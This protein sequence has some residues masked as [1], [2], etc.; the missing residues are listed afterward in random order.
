VCA[1]LSVCLS[2]FRSMY[3]RRGRSGASRGAAAWPCRTGGRTRAGRR[4][5]ANGSDARSGTARGSRAKA[6]LCVYA[7]TCAR[8]TGVRG[9]GRV[10]YAAHGCARGRH[11]L[12]S[13]INTSCYLVHASQPCKRTQ[14]FDGG[15]LNCARVE[16]QRLEQTPRRRQ[17]LPHHPPQ[18]VKSWLQARPL[19]V[20]LPPCAAAGT[21]VCASTTLC[22][23]RWMRLRER[24]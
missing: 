24:G 6:W 5:A 11:M 4:S 2:L 12:A 23:L 9:A 19:C 15:W 1:Y 22:A 20:C 13:C 14:S 8:A 3:V 7:C 10:R 18:Y 17:P 16:A 21:F